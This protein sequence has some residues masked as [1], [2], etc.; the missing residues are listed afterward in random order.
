MNRHPI[1]IIKIMFSDI[2]QIASTIK[3]SN[4]QNKSENFRPYL[5]LFKDSK[6]IFNSLNN[7]FIPSY[8]TSDLTIWFDVNIIVRINL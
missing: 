7:N 6:I 1:K 5:Q 3:S 8:V 2:P 4:E